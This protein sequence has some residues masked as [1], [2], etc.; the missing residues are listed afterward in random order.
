MQV[1]HPGWCTQGLSFRP[2]TIR[3]VPQGGLA[4][5]SLEVSRSPDPFHTD[6]PFPFPPRSFPDACHP[7][8]TFT[9][10]QQMCP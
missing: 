2:L 7:D 10:S 3:A 6:T 9:T 5:W 8:R 1:T 4:H